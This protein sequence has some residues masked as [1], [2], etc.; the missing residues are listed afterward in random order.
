V[1]AAEMQQE[2]MGEENFEELEAAA[3]RS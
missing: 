1:D 2:K 3:G